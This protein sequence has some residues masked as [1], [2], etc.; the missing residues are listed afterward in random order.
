MW[1]VHILEREK[2]APLLSCRSII[3]VQRFGESEV[4]HKEEPWGP[5]ILEAG[6]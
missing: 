3:K 1:Q 4:T 6:S 5:N 2:V